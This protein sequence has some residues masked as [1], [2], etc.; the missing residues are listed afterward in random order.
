M[1]TFLKINRYKLLLF[2]LFLFIL[3][4]LEFHTLLCNSGPEDS[5]LSCGN[6]IKLRSFGVIQ[7]AGEVYKKATY[8]K[9]PGVLTTM[10]TSGIPRDIILIVISALLSYLLSYIVYYTIYQRIARKNSKQL[11]R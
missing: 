6:N 1:Q 11:E 8:I 5:A 4:G 3:P 10:D 7:S 9:Q 2:V